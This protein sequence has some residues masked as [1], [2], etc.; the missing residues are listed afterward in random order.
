MHHAISLFLKHFV[1]L[2]VPNNLKQIRKRHNFT[3]AELGDAIGADQS[4]IVG[5]E[6]EY[7]QMD[8]P[9]INRLCS[10]LHVTPNE[11]LGIT[12]VNVPIK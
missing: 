8:V 3:Q 5:Y 11:L 1:I 6:K 9:T 10:I 7:R 2:T 4:T 12:E